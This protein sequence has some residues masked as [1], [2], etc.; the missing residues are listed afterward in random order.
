MLND[1]RY[2]KFLFTYLLIIIYFSILLASSTTTT[3]PNNY[4]VSLYS[5][6]YLKKIIFKNLLLLSTLNIIIQLL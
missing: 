5:N 4:A 6:E 3:K 1:N 2:P